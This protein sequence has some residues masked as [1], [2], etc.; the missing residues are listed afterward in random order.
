MKVA[1]VGSG[2]REHALAI[3]LGRT[4]EVVVTPG[5]SL[6]PG[7]T[8]ESIEDLVAKGDIDLVVI[9]SENDLVNDEATKLR[10]L[11]PTTLV[12][13]PDAAGAQIEG[14]KKYMKQLAD[15]AGIRTAAYQAFDRGEEQQ[16]VHF[17]AQLLDKYGKAVIKTS[18]LK[19]GKGVKIVNNVVDAQQDIVEKMAD[20]DGTIIIEE[21]VSG[22]EV[23]VFAICDGT[24]A[25]CLPAAQDFKRLKNGD[26]GPNT[27]GMG[28][29]SPL[30]FL[31]KNF[32]EQ[33]YIDFIDPTLTELHK[34]EI[35][36]RGVLYAGLVITDDGEVVLYEY[37]VRFG[38]PDSQ[39]VLLRMTSDLA[40]L[41]VAAAAGDLTKVEAP[42]F[43]DETAVLVVAAAEGYAE[44]EE[45][46]KGDV[47]RGIPTAERN[48]DV[49]V[50]GAGVALNDDQQL[51]TAGGRVLNVLGSGS[52]AKNAREKV[53]AALKFIG[54]NGIQ[55][56]DDIAEN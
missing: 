45:L 15:D 23:S 9:G 41:L 42:T 13:G 51:V 38:D 10:Q 17:A 12:F 26:A 1:V 2:G 34:R 47:I 33:I 31:P 24:R 56:R 3:A 46:R 6:I 36:F 30:P 19:G 5:N 48:D 25:I 32:E 11:N 35:D 22:T 55:Y 54:F 49:R 29:W 43:T 14:S 21:F 52:D 53:Y 40:A 8:K 7:S 28:A 18:Y 50:L 4:A 16:A 27:G 44:K 39:V 37:N 20:K